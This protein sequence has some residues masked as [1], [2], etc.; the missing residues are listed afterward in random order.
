HTLLARPKQDVFQKGFLGYLLKSK[1]VRY[2]IQK[3]SQGSK[4]L[5]INAGRLSNIGVSFPE[6]E[7]QKKIADCLFVLDLKINTQSKIIEQLETLIKG[8]SEK[9]FS[10]K[11]RFNE[12]TD[13]WK[14]KKL[15]EVLIEP[16][17]IPVENPNKIELL[18]VKLHCKGIEN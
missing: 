11:I 16:K 8:L 5:S 10:Q 4:V 14:T 9:L 3:E 15:K 18:S 12:F 2:Q 7:E 6:L 1:S 13:E 17:Q